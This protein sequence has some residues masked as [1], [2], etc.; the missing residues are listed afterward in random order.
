MVPMLLFRLYKISC[1][2]SCIPNEAFVNRI[3]FALLTFERRLLLLL[4]EYLGLRFTLK[5]LENVKLLEGRTT[6]VFL[7][8]LSYVLSIDWI[9]FISSI[10]SFEVDSSSL[11]MLSIGLAKSSFITSFPFFGV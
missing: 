11:G 3:L 1:N 2:L 10:S 4:L 7:T 6:E 8:R 5:D 9:S